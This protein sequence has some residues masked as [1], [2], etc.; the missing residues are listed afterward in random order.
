MRAALCHVRAVVSSFAVGSEANLEVDDARLAKARG[1]VLEPEERRALAPGRG[2]SRG[3]GGRVVSRDGDDGGRVDDEDAVE[4]GDEGGDAGEG[5]GGHHRRFAAVVVA[6]P[7]IL[8]SRASLVVV[9]GLVGLVV[10]VVL[11]ALPDAL[12]K[13]E[14]RDALPVVRRGLEEVPAVVNKR[15]QADALGRVPSHLVGRH[16]QRREQILHL[17][18]GGGGDDGGGVVIVVIARGVHRGRVR[19]DAGGVAEMR[20]R[21]ILAPRRASGDDAGH[22]ALLDCGRTSF[23]CRLLTHHAAGG[24]LDRQ[25]R[26]STLEK[27]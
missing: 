25:R 3:G 16:P 6:D 12:V 14:L 23:P 22:G 24:W 9:G 13:R 18:D 20:G 2:V 21:A 19:R 8:R 5:R 11:D 15:G 1:D 17:V 10:L 26:F 7:M 4:L 27:E